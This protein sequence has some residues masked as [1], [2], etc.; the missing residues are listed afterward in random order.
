MFRKHWCHLVQLARSFCKIPC[1]Y[2]TTFQVKYKVLFILWC[3]HRHAIPFCWGCW[4]IRRQL[5]LI[6]QH[7]TTI[8]MMSRP[9]LQPGCVQGTGA[10]IKMG[11]GRRRATQVLWRWFCSTSALMQLSVSLCQNPHLIQSHIAKRRPELSCWEKSTIK[12][13][14]VAQEDMSQP[15]DTSANGREI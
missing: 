8:C 12:G 3:E 4:E 2:S 1:S 7:Y 9:Y 14:A 13:L 10:G 6:S 15:F 11:V 5:A